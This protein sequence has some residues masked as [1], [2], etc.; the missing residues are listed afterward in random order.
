MSDRRIWV[1]LLIS[2]LIRGALPL[3]SFLTVHDIAVFHNDDSRSYIRPAKSLIEEGRFYSKGKPE[4]IRTPGYPVLLIPGLGFDRAVL[5]TVSLQVLIGCATVYLVFVITRRLTEDPNAPLFAATLAAVEPLSILFVTQIRAETLFAFVMAVFTLCLVNYIQS[6]SV[7]HLVAAAVLVALGAYV[8]PVALGVPVLVGALL[9]TW[10]VATRQQIA[11][12]L[13]HALVFCLIATALIGAW[14][15]RNTVVA[16]YPRFSAITDINLY[17]Y[18]AAAVLAR[19]RGVSFDEQ[20]KAMMQ[21]FRSR[22]PELDSGGRSSAL[23]AMGKEGMEIIARH[24]AAYLR[25][26]LE[27]AARS[28]A[29]PGLSGFLALF[30]VKDAKFAKKTASE[31]HRYSGLGFL[32]ESFLAA[33]PIVIWGN[34]FLGSLLLLYYGLGTIGAVR[35]G[36]RHPFCTAVLL[37]LIAYFVG[38][39]SNGYSRFRHPAMP[40]L[41]VLAGIGLAVVFEKARLNWRRRRSAS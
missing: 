25:V 38:S 13:V 17:Q 20:H 26:H 24:P 14:V 41:C 4:V 23:L 6:R 36:L 39:A 11:V 34:L 35:A 22:Y 19:E 3:T 31:S 21:D 27:G 12:K 28:L 32:W 10:T 1:I 9:V 15:V 37:V 29:G 7:R 30:K 8:R 16:D 40:L 33:S 5:I 18:N 2:L